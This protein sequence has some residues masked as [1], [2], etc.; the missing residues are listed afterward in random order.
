M[1]CQ[2]TMCM[3]MHLLRI[4]EH[5]FIIR[6]MSKVLG[7]A[8][9]RIGFTVGNPELIKALTTVKNSFNHFPVDIICKTTAKAAL[10]ASDY[11]EKITKEIK[12]R[13]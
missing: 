6:T 5:I 10:K 12:D 4:A 2:Q 13:V 7:L 9:M 3:T 1:I 11:Y 8:G